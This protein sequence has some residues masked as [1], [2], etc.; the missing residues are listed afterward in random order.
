MIVVNKTLIV[1]QSVYSS[2]RDGE[3][4][5]EQPLY[6]PPREPST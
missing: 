1:E 4:G 5:F 3:S 6:G 2:F